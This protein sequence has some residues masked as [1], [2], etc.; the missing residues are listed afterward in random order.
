MRVAEGFRGSLVN[1]S[2]WHERPSAGLGGD[3]TR[4]MT[5]W[6]ITDAATIEEGTPDVA[7]IE[8]QLADRHA[9]ASKEV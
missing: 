7:R 8:A 5:G 4:D 1:R 9:D 3:D 6:R 2:P